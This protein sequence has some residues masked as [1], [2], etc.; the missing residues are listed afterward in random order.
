MKK[1]NPI[2]SGRFTKGHFV[3]EE[4]RRKMSERKK[5]NPTRYW[6]GKK[7]SEETNNKIRKTIIENKIGINTRFQK[8]HVQSK[9]A[10]VKMSERAKLRIGEK[11]PNW[12]GGISFEPYPTDWKDSLKESIRERDNYICQ[13][14]GIHQDELERKLDVHHKNY[15]KNNLN[16]DNLISL[17]NGC[18][19]KTNYNR[20]YWINY[21]NE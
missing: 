8:G 5:L 18:H 2:N 20:N 10:R 21:F 9:E 11:S 15:N 1:K 7:R 14:C 3:S 12:Q 6:L 13:M 19:S 4:M 17:C 16:P